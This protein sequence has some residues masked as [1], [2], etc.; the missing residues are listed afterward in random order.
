MSVPRYVSIR[1]GV[2]GRYGLEYRK[3]DATPVYADMRGG[4][5]PAELRAIADDIE[6]R[7]AEKAKP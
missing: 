5:T 2:F 7:E 4:W 1:A 3:D 6:R